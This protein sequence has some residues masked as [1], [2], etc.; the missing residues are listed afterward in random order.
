M[1]KIVIEFDTVEKTVAVTRDGVAVANVVGATV[2]R[3]C[4]DEYGCELC[5]AEKDEAHDVRTYT[6][7]CAAELAKAGQAPAAAP[8]FVTDGLTDLQRDVCAFMERT[9]R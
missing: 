1:A 6:R 9:R 2:G 7:I 3:Y 5:L 4:D 8:G